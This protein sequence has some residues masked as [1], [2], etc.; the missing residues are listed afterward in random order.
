MP[1][2]KFGCGNFFSVNLHA[3]FVGF[4]PGSINLLP[5]TAALGNLAKD[6]QLRLR[7]FLTEQPNSIIGQ[8]IWPPTL[9]SAPALPNPHSAQFFQSR[10][11]ST[12]QHFN[13]N[14]KS[15]SSSAEAFFL[16]GNILIPDQTHLLLD[17]VPD[18][19]VSILC[20]VISRRVSVLL[21]S[22]LQWVLQS[23]L[24]ASWCDY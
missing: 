17:L 23:L 11:S 7:N 10:A 9:Y 12:P 21:K 20:L 19:L 14:E 24:N 18:S 13:W 8:K 2:L 5:P 1:M 6:R 22:F 3:G 15:K 16:F 4:L